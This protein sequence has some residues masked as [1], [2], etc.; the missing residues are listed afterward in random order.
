[1]LSFLYDGVLFLLGLLVLPKFALQMVNQK[2][3]RASFKQRFSYGLPNFSKGDAHLIWLHAISVGETRA[4]VPLYN[5]LKK[6]FPQSKI[7]I[8]NIT[9]TGHAEAKRSMKGADAYFYL[10]LDFSFLAKKV[11]KRFQ[12]DLLVLV[13][14]DFWYNLLKYAKKSGAKI[15]LVNGKISERSFK[16]FMCLP[17]LRKPLFALFDLL[18]VQ[19]EIYKERFIKMGIDSNKV[20]VTGNVKFDQTPPH[21]SSSEIAAWKR[22]LGISLTDP[23]LVIG[24]THNPE[25]EWLLNALNS[26]WEKIPTLKVILV[27]R[28]PERFTPIAS[29]LT[30]KKIPF[31]SY[32]QRDSHTGSEKVLLVDTM[33]LLN[34]CYQMADIAIVAGSF[35]DRIGGHNVFEPAIFG[36]P[37]L[38][39]PHMFGQADLTK[40]VLD[41]KAGIQVTL[42]ELPQILLELFENNT[43]RAALSKAGLKLAQESKG[44]TDRTFELL[45]GL[46]LNKIIW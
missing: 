38:F 12:P 30:E 35:T 25:E 2:K 15:A 9:E 27:P 17:F 1:M 10:P 18:S 45:K 37:V 14:S 13:E 24:S 3:Y 7:V 5:M 16:R 6:E 20:H 44:S 19:S 36:T 41:A 8:S 23:I 34:N 42:Q 22:S 29:L 39:G 26:V 40:A 43:L 32:S 11:V 31:C 46:A 4:I 28:H 33:G 21:L